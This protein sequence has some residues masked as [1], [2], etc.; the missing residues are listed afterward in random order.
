M[1]IFIFV[2]LGIEKLFSQSIFEIGTVVV[3]QREYEKAIMYC[4]SWFV[5]SDGSRKL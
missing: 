5:H 1:H 4:K 2:L 3:M